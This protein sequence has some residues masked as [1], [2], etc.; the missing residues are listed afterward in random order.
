MSTLPPVHIL[1]ENP[2]WLPPL[3]DALHKEGFEYTEI[4]V[5]HGIISGPPA[6]GIYLNRMSPSSHTRGHLTSVALTR[7]ILAHLQ[8]HGARVVNGLAAFELEMSKLRQHL[9][10]QRFGIRTPRT[11][12]AVGTEH[13]VS[14][15][16]TFEGPF[17]TK[18][19]RGGK[20]LGIERFENA[21]E[22]QD[23]LA[24]GDFDLGPDHQVLI[25]Q[26]IQAPEPFITRVEIV[27]QRMIFAMRSA[28]DEGFQL[29]PSDVC[30][31]ELQREKAQAAALA[32]NCPIDGGAKFSQS[33]LKADD[34][35]VLKYLAMCAASGIELAGIEFVEDAHGHRYTYDINGTTN[36]N[37]TLGRQMGIHGMEELATY[38]RH[39]VAPQ[40]MAELG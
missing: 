26:Y 15:A 17:I 13:L 10:L 34:P 21:D 37:Q 33:P 36:Y 22:L 38:L 24:Q 7:E 5:H 30:Q 18:H 9:T 23:R 16:R 29:C 6:P 25:Q 2:D 8:A 14:L 19:N 40:V 20:G 11:A 27:G 1:F 3:R 31:V 32:D 28:T 4:P 35:L 12:L 39:V